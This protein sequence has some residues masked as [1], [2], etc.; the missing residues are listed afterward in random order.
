ML[1]A[2]KKTD[3]GPKPGEAPLQEVPTAAQ[4][5][6][7]EKPIGTHPKQGAGK[8]E[9]PPVLQP[10][11]ASNVRKAAEAEYPLVPPGV[12]VVWG[13]KWKVRRAAK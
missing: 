7:G 10:K 6:P 5:G 8:L 4:A 11:W 13:S 1:A 9:Q 12:T 2:D 3:G